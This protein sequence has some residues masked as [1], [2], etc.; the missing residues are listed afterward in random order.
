MG[1]NHGITTPYI[2]NWNLNV[3]QALWRNA[4]ATIAYVANKGV[5]LYSIRDI[6]QN[7]YAND[8]S[9]MGSPAAPMWVHFPTWVLSTCWATVI[10]RC[11]TAC[12]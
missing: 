10:T 8:T 2:F 3:E 4:A 12:S 6:N 11:T 7:I 1:V 9:Q 5:Q